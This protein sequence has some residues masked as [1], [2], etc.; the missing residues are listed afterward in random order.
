MSHNFH[1]CCIFASDHSLF[2][3]QYLCQPLIFYR[4]PSATLLLQLSGLCNCNKIRC[5]EHQHRCLPRGVR[6]WACFAMRWQVCLCEAAVW[7][8]ALL[9][10]CHA[11]AGQLHLGT[12]T[13]FC[14]R[15]PVALQL[16]S[17]R[18]RI[19]LW[20]NLQDKLEFPSS[21]LDSG[22]SHQAYVVLLHICNSWFGCSYYSPKTLEAHSHE[23]FLTFCCTWVLR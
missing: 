18:E 6:S 15:E 16:N 8:H 2:G 14:Q 20:G 5:S 19:F 10:T 4:L 17:P 13:E 22:E 23:E 21:L 9:E 11:G 3:D 7:F 12:R 1:F